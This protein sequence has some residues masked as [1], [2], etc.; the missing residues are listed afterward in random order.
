VGLKRV[1]YNEHK[2]YV[3]NVGNDMNLKKIRIVFRS[4]LAVFKIWAS[5][6]EI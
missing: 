4:I 2:K 5:L 1:L 3:E 6:S